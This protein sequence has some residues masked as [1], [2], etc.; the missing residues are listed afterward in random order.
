MDSFVYQYPVKQYF[1]KGCAEEAIKKEL[2]TIGRNVLLAYGGGSL[3]RTGLYEKL[4]TWLEEAGKQ[5]T[6]FGGIMPN[7]TYN[8]VQE[9]AVLVK[10]HKIDFILAAGGGSVLDC[11]KIVSAQAKLEEDIWDMQYAKHLYAKEFVPMGAVV[12]ASGTGAE[13][14]NGAVITHE[15]KKLKQALFGAYYSF[16]VLD[17]DLTKT[18]PMKQ[19]ISGAFDTLSHCMETYMGRPQ[20]TN[21]SDEINEAIM[22][23]V[24]KNLRSLIKN[25]DD[26]FARGELMWASAIAENGMLKLGK[27]TDFQCHMIEH[28]VGA[29]TD[30]NHGQGLAV[31]HPALYRHLLDSGKEKLARMA[32]TVWRV[33]GRTTEETAMRG[34]ETLE[35]F[36]REIGLPTH[37]S[38]MGI[39]DETVLRAAA[40]TSIIMPGCCRQFSRDEIF[41]ILKER[42]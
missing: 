42:V 34:I 17:S 7:P 1:G 8:K 9:G 25:P 20:E 6:D 36:I 16:A 15:E 24:I 28:A 35:A 18:L 21:L 32:E 3:K 39:T 27:Q 13:Q 14:N 38:E 19:V 30:C 2:K 11:C 37:W 4:R 5:V 40:D 10:K 12:T 29:Y 33:K 41:E 23:N 26:D 31:I 22:R